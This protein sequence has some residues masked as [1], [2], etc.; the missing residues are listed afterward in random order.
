M[1][2]VFGRRPLKNIA[3]IL[4]FVLIANLC[5][6][7]A[8][9]SPKQELI[10]NWEYSTAEAP[11]QDIHWKPFKVPGQPRE[12]SPTS[13][14]WVRAM[15]PNLSLK[16]PCLFFITNDQVF[17]VYVEDKL[18]YRYGEIQ[19]YND[20]VAPGSPWHMI[21]LPDDFAGKFLKIRMHT[22][23]PKNFGLVRRASIGNQSDFILEILRADISGIIV[24]VLFL[25]IGFLLIFIF[26]M[27]KGLKLAFPALGLFSISFGLWL[28]SETNFKQ[29]F[30]DA[31]R[32]WLYI[33]FSNF[34]LMPAFFSYFVHNVFDN[35]NRSII[36][37]L[38]KV[39]V[40]FAFGTLLLDVAGIS[41]IIYALKGFYVLLL[42]NI[43]AA[44]MTI[45]KAAL[46][47]NN[48]AK[49]FALG[50]TIFSMFGFYDILGWYFMVVPWSS[51]VVPYGM[52]IFVLTLVYLLARN[53]VEVY[54][55]IKAYSQE[56]ENK[57]EALNYMYTI[58]N[59]SREKLAEW[60]KSLEQTVANRTSAIRNLLNNAGQGFLSFGPDLIVHNEYSS[61][62]MSI[63]KEPIEGKLFYQLLY[64]DSRE[65]HHYLK[66][67]LQKVL[68][69]KNPAVRQKYLPLLPDEVQLNN[70]HIHID[71]KIIDA[72]DHEQ[73]EM[74]MVILTDI[75]DK[76]SLE[77]QMEKERNT[78]KMIVK[79][80]TNY[81]DFIENIKDFNHFFLHRIED[82]LSSKRSAKDM[83]F[84]IFRQVHTFK[85]SFS[86]LDMLF[87]VDKLHHLE[88]DLSTLGGQ[89]DSSSVEKLRSLL[90]Q[91]DF[92]SWLTNELKTLTDILGN[93]FLTQESALTIDKSKLLELENKIMTLLSPHECKLILPDIKRLRHKPFK[94]VLKGMPYYVE[95]LAEREGKLVHQV[96]IN[97]DDVLVDLDK[98]SSFSKAL[99]QIFRNIV[100]HGIEAP[101]ERIE[102][103]KHEFGNILCTIRERGNLIELVIADDGRGLNL[104]A[105]RHKALEKGILSTASA[106]S[107]KEEALIDLIFVDQLSTKDTITDLSGRG[108]G[109]SVVK[110]EVLKLNGSVSVETKSG[111]GT[112]F[113][114]TFPNEKAN[115]VAKISANALVKPL[116][117][118]AKGFLQKHTSL[119]IAQFDSYCFDKNES[120]AL[121]E[122]TSFVEIKGILNGRF[123]VSVDDRLARLITQN[124][125]LEEMT[126]EEES[127]LVIDVVAEFSNIVV[128]NSIHMLPELDSLIIIEPPVSIHLKDAYIRFMEATSWTCTLITDMGN[129][130]I[131]FVSKEYESLKGLDD[132]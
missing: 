62:C 55:Q 5:L 85:G 48:E 51:Y 42:L 54:D 52:L 65:Q 102:S 111:M 83:L 79:V 68:Q 9:E 100:D 14:V 24:S 21:A 47:G 67:I 118:T 78:L 125:I 22:M 50:I 43:L 46:S 112:R 82:V 56:I 76:R 115:S 45:I 13:D 25:F 103:G 128:G 121:K 89:M 18:I 80:I 129:I 113:I 10:V 96:D 95:R 41:P 60:N 58:V 15:L 27:R 91:H 40:G 29:L 116:I 20:K 7:C 17:E 44:I 132:K 130:S 87:I 69:E 53:I 37:V 6:T 124:T 26:F 88:T 108:I 117:E 72:L 1:I 75:T 49:I 126:E 98:Y 57:N 12:T 131:S 104:E 94:E 97:E 66:N 39:D 8:D 33:A 71:Y 81:K 70:K 28:I 109:L 19:N 93:Q 36:G 2:K 38:W 106:S 59:D 107:L 3:T 73:S 31:P 92:N 110:N 4:L 34:F 35:T 123:V 90:S 127:T 74:F 32:L 120:I 30:L 11:F 64:P 77:S 122:F 101:E 61:E 23:F 119:S 114:F 105:I 16:S 63:F 86:Q 99:I 84:E